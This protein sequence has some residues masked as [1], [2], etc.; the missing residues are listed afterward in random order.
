MRSPREAFCGGR[1]NA[2]AAH[3]LDVPVPSKHLPTAPV[4]VD[5]RWAVARRLL[6]EPNIEAS[7]RVAGALAVIYAQ[8][9]HRINRLTTSDLTDN[10]RD[11]TVQFGR[12]A[13]NLPEPLASH[14]RTLLASTPRTRNAN[15]AVYTS[16]LFPG[17]DPGRPITQAGLSRRLARLGVRAG[18]HRRAALFQLAAEMPATRRRPPR[19]PPPDGGCLVPSRGPRLGRLPRHAAW[20]KRSKTM[21]IADCRSALTPRENIEW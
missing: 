19:N 2:N 15:F 16:W 9:L 5:D 3:P 17:V 12:T 20:R 13:I 21:K 10:E 11:V 4:D 14:A 1:D 8:P 7:D 6:H 18:A